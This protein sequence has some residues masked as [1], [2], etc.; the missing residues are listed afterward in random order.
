MFTRSAR[1][2]DAIYSFKDYQAEAEEVH[3]LIRRS[4]PDA[5][6]LLD[7]ACGTGMHLAHLERHY[8]VVGLDLE[9]TLL[10][11]ARRRLPS[12]QLHRADMMAFGLG[13]RF[14]A[15]TCLFSSIGYASEEGSMRRA[16]ASMAEHLNDGGVLVVEGWITPEAWDPLGAGVHQAEHEGRKVVRMISS[17]REGDLSILDAHYLV[18]D[19]DGSIEHLVEEH[20]LG[21]YTEE[22]YVGAFEAAGLHTRVDHEALMGRGVYVG[23]R[24]AS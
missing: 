8:E 21:M 13:R 5:R 20:R 1:Y 15:V 19:T 22:Q 16:I 18:E 11:I 4:A 10:E 23:V 9:P 14:D 6:S 2:Y 12:V 3:Q 7:V 17:R 24:R